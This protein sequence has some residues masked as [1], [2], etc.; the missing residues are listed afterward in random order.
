VLEQGL[1][2]LIQTALAGS[3][4]VA[5]VPGGFYAQLPK[6]QID[7]TK[8]M[9][10]TYRFIHSEPSYFIGGQD[11]FTAATVQ[12]DCHGYTQ[13]NAITL[14]L[15]IDKILRGVFRGTLADPDATVVD[16]IFREP[17]FLDGFSDANRSYVRSLEYLI[18]YIQS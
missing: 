5:T 9:A 2:L 1:V 4:P 17:T 16:S 7:A 10:W 12:I 3:P 8:T 14:A 18:N 11:P 6:D 13:A 15:A